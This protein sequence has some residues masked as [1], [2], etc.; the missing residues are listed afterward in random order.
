[1][2]RLFEHWNGYDPS[3]KTTER[4]PAY[5]LK[6]GRTD[7]KPWFETRELQRDGCEPYDG[8]T[9]VVVDGH[10][11]FVVR[12]LT[13]PGGPIQGWL[14]KFFDVPFGVKVQIARRQGPTMGP[15]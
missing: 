10:E 7:G 13:Y 6:V 1:M 5:S 9:K 12:A 4:E 11:L 15:C 8:Y 3:E 14:D 2:P